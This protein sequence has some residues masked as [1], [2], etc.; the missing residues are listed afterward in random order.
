MA[1]GL[2]DRTQ[3]PLCDK[4]DN[5]RLCEISF[6]DQRLKT[7]LEGFYAGRVPLKRFKADAFRVVICESCKLIYQDRILNA[8]GM[9]ALYLDW[10]DHAE[11]LQKKKTAGASLYG[12]YAG[13]L[14]SLARIL[15]EPPSACRMLDYGMGWGYWARMAQAHGYQV[16][17]YEL[18]EQR[19]A[20]A[21]SLGI[22]TIDRLPE[23]GSHYHGI[24]ANQVFE[25]LA[26]PKQALRDLRAC[27]AP[28]G[29]IYLR[30]PDGRGVAD[31]LNER[32][33]SPDLDAIHPF[34]HINCFTRK[35]LIALAHGAGLKPINAPFRLNR[36][37]LWS[38]LR[39]EFADRYVTTHLLLRAD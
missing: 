2:I 32:G 16:E 30:V 14:S 17:G 38:S 7:Y 8:Q 36:N 15:P 4:Q 5:R 11:S 9:Q 37:S 6:K 22:T 24:Y 28:G 21:R 39:R 33:W 20:H 13:Q 34:E 19:S 3:C 31:W 25:H 1:I 12:K 29:I 27:L 23:P 26:D 18:S 35:T 10:I